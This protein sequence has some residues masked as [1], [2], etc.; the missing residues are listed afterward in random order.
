MSTNT[1]VN[2]MQKLGP[3]K[4][5]GSVTVHAERKVNGKVVKTGNI[6]I[7]TLMMFH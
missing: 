1:T 4:T 5:D 3:L 7:K 6:A 2:D